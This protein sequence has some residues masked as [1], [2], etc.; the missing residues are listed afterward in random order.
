[1]VGA[2]DLRKKD[3]D[4]PIVSWTIFAIENL[5]KKAVIAAG[6]LLVRHC[7]PRAVWLIEVWRKRQ[8]KKEVGQT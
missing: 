2:Y 4:F 6:A 8:I 3:K 1:M 7:V 5:D